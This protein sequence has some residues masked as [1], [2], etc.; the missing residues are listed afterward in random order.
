MGVPP[1]I[2]KIYSLSVWCQ[3]GEDTS[4]LLCL[5][6][7]FSD[8]SFFYRAKVEEVSNFVARTIVQ[9][10]P[11]GSRQSIKHD[12]YVAYC[13]V[14]PGGLASVVLADLEYDQRVAFGC[15]E[16]ILD[17][18]LAQYP[19]EGQNCTEELSMTCPAIADDLVTFQDIREAD[20]ITKIN[21]EL[22][23]V[24]EVLHRSIDEVLKRGEK[25]DD[26]VAKSE[27]LTTES[28]AFLQSSKDATSCCT[29]L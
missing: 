8:F 12:Q 19:C 28:K 22:D 5:E 21:S 1:S 20:K 3:K 7:D 24:K 6:K 25:L 4:L 15:C 9:R 29:L 26:I 23:E 13:R 11:Q 2:M 18:F 10:T 27:D 16:Q 14:R 17:H